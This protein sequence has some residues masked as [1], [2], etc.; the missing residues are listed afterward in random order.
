MAAS[1]RSEGE[2]DMTSRITLLG[3]GRMG[4]ALARA[5]LAA[6]LPL[7]VYNRT[8][9]RAAPLAEHGAVVAKSLEEALDAADVVVGNLSDYAATRA[10]LG[11]RPRAL[12]KKTFVELASGTP[13]QA[14]EAAAWLGEHGV[15]YLDGAIMATPEFVARPGCTILYSGARALFEELAGLRDALGDNSVFVGEDVGHANALDNALLVVLW[16]SLAGALQGAAI[17]EAEKVSLAEFGASL[18]GLFPV[19]E[20]SLADAIARAASKR[21]A[22]DETTAATVATCHASVR[23]VLGISREHA[24]DDGLPAYLDRVFERAVAA[25]HASADFSAVYTALR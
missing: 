9:A 23:Y 2:I 6:R 19:I 3:T 20:A 17:A 10:M 22:A 7:T 16:G 18:K 15:R 25:G 8:I 12:A 13:G 14:R 1:V 5:L 21:F 4:S 11:D 24:I